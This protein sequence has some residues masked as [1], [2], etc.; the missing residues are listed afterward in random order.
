MQGL[1]QNLFESLGVCLT[2]LIIALYASVSELDTGCGFCVL[3]VCNMRFAELILF[4][5]SSDHSEYYPAVAVA[6][7]R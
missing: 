5:C 7:S 2:F 6:G 3:T 4:S 1:P